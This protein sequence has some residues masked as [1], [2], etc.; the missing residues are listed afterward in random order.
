MPQR[1]KYCAFSLFLSVVS[2]FA[3]AQIPD[4]GFAARISETDTYRMMKLNSFR[5]ASTAGET[6][7]VYQRMLWRVD[8][9]VN[10]ISGVITSHFVVT[11][12]EIRQVVFDLSGNMRVD[13]V[14][15]RNA[16]L[17]FSHSQNLLTIFL[18]APL[19]GGARDSLSVFYQ[20]QPLSSGFGSFKCSKHNNTP[21]MWTLSE[22]YGA[23]DWWPCKQSLTDKIDSADIITITPEVYRTA[24]NGL[25]IS[26]K[27]SG[28]DRITHW[29][30]S[31]PIA[32]YLVAI[33]V[34]NYVDYT[35]TLRLDIHRTLPVLNYVYPE[36]LLPAK[37]KTPVTRDLIALYNQLFGEYPFS[38]EKY[39][40][41]EFGW[42]GGMEHQT[43][44]FMGNFEFELIAHELAH[45]WFGNCITLATWHDIWLNEGFATYATGLAY[46]RMFD[47]RHWLQWKQYT[48]NNI[49]ESPSGSVYVSDTSSVSRI[50]NGRLSY[51][52]GSY[53]LHMLRWKLGDSA[54]FR[55]LKNYFSDSQLK[56]KFATHRQWVDHLESAAGL[57]L[58]EFFNDWYYGEGY[59][60]YSAD[61]RV[62]GEK[63]LRIKLSQTTSHS[64]VSFFEMPVPLRCYSPGRKDSL[65]LRLDHTENDQVFE[66]KLPFLVA[67]L[68][69]DPDM[70]LIRKIDRITS[71][72]PLALHESDILVSPNPSAGNWKLTMNGQEIARETEIFTLTGHSVFRKKTASNSII[73][74]TLP[75]GTYLLKVTTNQNIYKTKL[76][77]Q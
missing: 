57:S 25:L 3:A 16:K 56:Y 74:P 62:S 72:Q 26:E 47:G 58:T 46:E 69:I 4:P 6:D 40:H 54:F 33:A 73:L 27:I 22:P 68:V 9:A 55:A 53:L 31:Y 50:F 18:G 51:S 39:G 45:S 71:S 65:D 63:E 15:R 5:E 20:G 11:H 1:I 44:S 48:L 12:P 77:R 64:S 70:W 59:P 35:D 38:E 36:N 21:V 43:M 60:V 10:Y 37:T 61:F 42:N 28:T 49:L 76:V 66:F 14:V 23:R 67:E 24:S 75:A 41:A 19:P 8:P 52:K 34:T 7:M 30:H 2:V 29:K 13:S 17:E 32:T